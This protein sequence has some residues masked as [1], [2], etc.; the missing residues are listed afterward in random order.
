MLLVSLALLVCAAVAGSVCSPRASA[1]RA[2]YWLEN[3]EEWV[4]EGIS[5]EAAARRQK[6]DTAMAELRA[7]ARRTPAINTLGPESIQFT[8][9]ATPTLL[10]AL[11]YPI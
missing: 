2:H 6:F 5:E 4:N 11:Y 1:R 8:A 10:R 3:T 7:E 9:D